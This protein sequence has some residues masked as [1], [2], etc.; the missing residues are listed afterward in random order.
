MGLEYTN[1]YTSKD[2]SHDG[3]VSVV[4][5]EIGL[6][7]II[8]QCIPPDIRT[9]ISVGECV[10]LMIINGLCFSSRPLYLESQFFENK[11][12][13]RFLGRPIEA[14]QINDDRLGRCLDRCFEHGCDALFARI[15]TRAAYPYQ[16]DRKF[17]HLDTTSMSVDGDYAQED[18][19]GLVQFGY[20]KD[21]RSDLKQ[22]MISLMSSQDG[23][24]PL[25]AQTIA[26][27]SSDKV[28][29]REVL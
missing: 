25:L 28:H 1:E 17:R 9:Q 10:K 20:S 29:F 23:D 6:V 3:I 24:V 16:V 8:D 18:G 14:G 2:L 15:A 5:D 11:P 12:V 19:L 27:N 13:E 4:C 26:G 22:F 7:E 21:R